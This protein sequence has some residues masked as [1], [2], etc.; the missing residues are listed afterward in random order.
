MTIAEVELLNVGDTITTYHTGV[1]KFV[2]ATP[3]F[4]SESNFP[5]TAAFRQCYGNDKE[6]KVGDLYQYLVYYTQI[7]DGEFKP[8]R[9]KVEKSCSSFYCTKVSVNDLIDRKIEEL[10]LQIDEYQRY[11]I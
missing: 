9:G 7:C 6:W 8:K 4:V 11:K 5:I 3:C 10:K 2:K 1:F